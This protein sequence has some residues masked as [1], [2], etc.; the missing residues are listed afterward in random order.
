MMGFRFPEN[1]QSPY[2][3]TSLA[4]F[5]HRWHISLSTFLRDYLYIP[6]GG[7]RKGPA[8]T[9]LNLLVVMLIGGFWHGAQWN[10][11]IWGGIHGLGLAVERSWKS[12]IRIPLP[13]GIG[14]VL[15]TFVLLITWVFFRA[16][17]MGAAV[18]YLGALFGTSGDSDS[19]AVLG[20]V[21]LT[22]VN[23]VFLIACAAVV[24]LSPNTGSWLRHLR[25]W[26]VV[27]GLVLLC[28]SVRVLGVQ[29]FNPFLYFQF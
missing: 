16:P 18:T 11:V 15:T 4:D 6:L 28:I 20:S 21:V 17:S 25:G 3:A 12:R 2:R 24:W 8:R 29:G 1:F 13:R 22:P 9:Y 27:A 14:W 10:Y 23:I 5:W 7:S 26:K 19:A